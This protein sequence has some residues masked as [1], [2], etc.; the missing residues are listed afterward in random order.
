MGYVGRYRIIQN[1]TE[2][3][4]P[5]LG[6]DRF[7]LAETNVTVKR[8]DESGKVMQ[9]LTGKALVFANARDTANAGYVMVHQSEARNGWRY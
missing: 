5:R 2:V 7:G 6:D 9:T 4:I 1:S 8:L 3:V